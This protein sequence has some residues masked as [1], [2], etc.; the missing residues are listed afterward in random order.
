MLNL[1]KL[2]NFFGVNKLIYIKKAVSIE[3]NK[4]SK[5]YGVLKLVINSKDHF[6]SKI[7]DSNKMK[8]QLKI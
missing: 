4:F 5:N 3:H 1:E 2:K 8:N 6:N 7:F